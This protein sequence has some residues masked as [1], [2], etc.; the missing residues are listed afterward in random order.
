MF[1]VVVCPGHSPLP[2]SSAVSHPKRDLFAVKIVYTLLCTPKLS[3]RGGWPKGMLGPLTPSVSQE[4]TN[5]EKRNSDGS[6]TLS[7]SS[8]IW[9]CCLS[10]CTCWS[11]TILRSCLMWLSCCSTKAWGQGGRG[12]AV[13]SSRRTSQPFVVVIFLLFSYPEQF[14]SVRLALDSNYIYATNQKR[15]RFQCLGC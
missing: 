11:S 15:E 5:S 9:L 3:K 10:S 14:H 2:G 8:I 6:C 1:V 7:S 12:I 13:R 4:M